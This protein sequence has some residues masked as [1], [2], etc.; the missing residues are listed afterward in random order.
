M[1]RILCVGAEH[2]DELGATPDSA[3]LADAAWIDLVDPTDTERAAVEQATGLHMRSRADLSEI[4]NSSRLYAHGETLYL[5]LPLA[6]GRPRGPSST[7]P[8]GFVLTPERLVTIRFVKLPAFDWY[9]EQPSRGAGVSVGSSHVFIELIE[10]LTD[11]MA[12][13]LELIRDELDTI[14]QHIFQPDPATNDGRSRDSTVLRE[15][16]QTVGRCGDLV[17]RV[18]DT[19]LGIDRI[20]QYVGP[21]AAQRITPDLRQ[22]LKTLRADVASLSD[23]D[24]HLGSKAQLLLDA[25]LGLITIAQS[26]IIK[27]M[28]VVGVIGV[29][30]TLIAS[31]YGMNFEMMPE[32][33]LHYGYPLAMVMIVAS[34]LLPLMW[35]K[36]RGWL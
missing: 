25:I 12:D 24:G 16:L 36:R 26:N 9:I 4:E 18:R 27:V 3:R 19:L 14:S 11:A 31:I 35:F 21:A 7:S 32:L 22:R 2:P 15:S 17:S 30:P 10:R 23:Y 13:T 29:P 33:K 28:T 6:V 34:A 20:V 8:L 5:S 1:L